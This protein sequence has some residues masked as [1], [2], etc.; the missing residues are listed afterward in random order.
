MVAIRDASILSIGGPSRGST[1]SPAVVWHGGLR[2]GE[3]D[4]PGRVRVRGHARPARRC[5]VCSVRRRAPF[6]VSARARVCM[7]AVSHACMRVL[8]HGRLCACQLCAAGEAEEGWEAD[9]GQGDQRF[10]PF[11][12]GPAHRH[13]RGAAGPACGCEGQG[14]GDCQQR[15]GRERDRA[16]ARARSRTR[17][18]ARGLTRGGILAHTRCR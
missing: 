2:E 1:N 4:R 6:A 10:A 17:E 15:R 18:G 13:A 11:R 3:A 8:P 5:C 14:R 16:S 12:K 7:H 9:G